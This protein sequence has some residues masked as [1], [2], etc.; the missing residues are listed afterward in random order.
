MQLLIYLCL[1]DV[2]QREM[3][4]YAEHI[5]PQLEEHSMQQGISLKASCYQVYKYL[6]MRLNGDE[7]EQGTKGTRIG[8][9]RLVKF[10]PNTLNFFMKFCLY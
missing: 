6:L 7:S 2:N 3:H 1:Q 5:Q 8:V 10:F 4:S 9:D